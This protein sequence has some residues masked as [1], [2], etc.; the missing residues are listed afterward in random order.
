VLKGDLSLVGPR[1][2]LPQEVERYKP[3][4]R[5]VFAVK[6]GLTGLAQ[7]SGRS[8]LSFEEEARLDLR[9]VEEWS[10]LLDLWVLWR[11]PFVVLSRRGAD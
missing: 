10:M 7:V 2:H 6:P 4:E 3:E 8:D 5:R 1:P 11:T 9:Y